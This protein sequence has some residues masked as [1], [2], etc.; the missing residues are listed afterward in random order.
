MKVANSNLVKTADF[1]DN[2]NWGRVAAAIADKTYQA[3]HVPPC[4]LAHP[5]AIVRKAVQAWNN[6]HWT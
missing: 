5:R 4:R 2:P 1:V 3:K 6:L